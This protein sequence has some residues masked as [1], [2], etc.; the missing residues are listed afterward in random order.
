MAMR[1]RIRQDDIEELRR[2]ASIVDVASDYMKVRKAG[3]LFKAL[4]PFHTEKTPSFSIDPAKSL[5][6]CFGCNR[7]GDVFNLLE[8]L[9]GLSFAESAERLAR[10]FGLDLQYERLT[11]AQK[12]AAGK[13]GRLMDAHRAAIEHYRA[14]LFGPEGREAVDYLKGRGFSRETVEEFGVGLALKRRDDLTRA[15]LKVGFRADDLVE[16]GLA[17]RTEEGAPVD[18]FRGRIVFPIHDLTGNPVGFGARRLADAG[19]GPKYLNSPESPIYRK[20]SVLYALDKAKSEIVKSGR[21]LVVEGYTDVMALHQVGQRE[22]VATCGTA[23]GEGHFSTLRRFTTDVVLALD[24][25]EAG[26]AA[27]ERAFELVQDVQIEVRMLVLPGGKDPAE[28]VIESGAEAFRA[29]LEKS[30]PLF[31]YRLER[32]VARFLPTGDPARTDPERRGRAA[33]ALVP[34]LGRIRMEDVQRQYTASF[35]ERLGVADHVLFNELESFRR[36]GTVAPRTDARRFAPHARVEREAIK[37]ALQ[38]PDVAEQYLLE[39]KPEDFAAPTHRSIWAQILAGVTDAAGL[40]AR[41]GD[42]RASKMVTELAMEPPEGVEPGAD[43]IPGRL[44]QEIFSRLKEFSLGRQIEEVKARLQRLNP[45]EHSEEYESLAR[46]LF[47]LEGTRRRMAMAL[48]EG[49]P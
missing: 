34:I 4:C 15:L 8:G 6:Y 10:R 22:V 31:K 35:A 5:W 14:A 7:G 32:E 20:G 43:E 27:A 26:L 16:A 3:R 21:A 47:A 28:F 25:D 19:E 13:R 2:K 42:A 30:E 36:T 48:R 12:E 44:P 11:P 40:V 39:T 41:L 29:H 24:S 17:V 46:E 37:L 23:I 33:R 49:E 45:I 9:E 18:R 1:G 38:Y